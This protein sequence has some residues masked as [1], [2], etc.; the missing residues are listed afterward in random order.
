MGLEQYKEEEAILN[1]LEKYVLLPWIAVA[2]ERWTEIFIIIFVVI[3][4]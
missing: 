3:V 4:Y 1:Q 2:E